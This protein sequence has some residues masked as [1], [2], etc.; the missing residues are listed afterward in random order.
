MTSRLSAAAQAQ[1]LIAQ[2]QVDAAAALLAKHLKA[3]PRDVEA[4]RQLARILA[5]VGDL[6]GARQR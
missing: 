3:H 5:N 2:G 4:L 1:D 6:N